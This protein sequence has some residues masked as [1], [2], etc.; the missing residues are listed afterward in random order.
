[1]L[2]S[3]LLLAAMTQSTQCVGGATACCST[4]C[5]AGAPKTAAAKA[6]YL[7]TVIDPKQMMAKA[8]EPCVSVDQISRVGGGRVAA[9]VIGVPYTIAL[10]FADAAVTAVSVQ[11]GAPLP[12]DTAPGAKPHSYLFTPAAE[13]ESLEAKV[14]AAKGHKLTCT[15]KPFSVPVIAAKCGGMTFTSVSGGSGAAS[16]TE[17]GDAPG[18]DAS[19]DDVSTIVGLLGSP[20]PLTLKGQGGKIYVYSSSSQ[21]TANSTVVRTLKKAILKLP[22]SEARAS[23]GGLAMD[24]TVPGVQATD[25][26]LTGG[27][28]KFKVTVVAAGGVE[29]AEAK[30]GASCKDWL[31]ELKAVELQA[32]P[33]V[34]ESRMSQLFYLASANDTA[35]VLT[36][37][38]GAS[39]G[40]SAAPVKPAATPVAKTPATKAAKTAAGAQGADDAGKTA[41]AALLGAP[42]S[43]ALLAGDGN[44]QTAADETP[45]AGSP[46]KTTTAAAKITDQKNTG[47]TD[48]AAAGQGFAVQGLQT[49]LLVFGG[50]DA[51]I[52]RAKQML[53]MLDLPRPEM[54]INT[55]ILQAST[56]NADEIG[57][58][59]ETARRLV[60]ENNEVLQ[61]GITQGWASLAQSARQPGFF[62][63]SFY[64]Y[65]VYRYIG[66]S[67]EGS[68]ADDAGREAMGVC[69]RGEYCLGYTTLFTPLRPR[70]T[71]VLLAMIASSKKKEDEVL[72][73]VNAAECPSL[74]YSALDCKAG[75][76]TLKAER[77]G[78][79]SG[80]RYHC[81]TAKCV[82]LRRR[83]GIDKQPCGSWSCTKIEQKVSA[84]SGSTVEDFSGCGLQDLQR[85]IDW[86]GS[87]AKQDGQAT[88]QLECFRGAIRDMFANGA[89]GQNLARGAIADFLYQYKVS[90]QYPQEFS[91]YNLTLS[92]DTL[93]TALAPFIDAFNRDVRAFQDYLNNVVRMKVD[94]QHCGKAVTFTDTGLVSVRTV[95]VNPAEV[96]ST[97]QSSLDAGEFPDAATLAANLLSG[98]NSSSKTSSTSLLPPNEATMILGALKSFQTTTAQIG[99]QIDV[100]VT[101]RSLPGA[102]AAEMDVT[103]KVDD[104]GTPSRYTGTT[105]EKLNLSR[106]ATHDTTTHVR[107]DSLKLFEVSSV[108]AQLTLSRPPIPLILPLVE[109]PYIGSL[110][111]IPRKPSEEYHSSVAIMSAI[112]VPTAADLAYG[113]TFVN[114]RIVVAPAGS[115][116][117]P[118]VAGPLDGLAPCVALTTA[119]QQEL[120]GPVHSFHRVKR[121][122]LSTG[123]QL[124]YSSLPP[125]TSDPP[126]TNPCTN[127]KFD[128]LIPET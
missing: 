75:A 34:K 74:S 51:S 58:F 121:Q 92:A 76:P 127:L 96:K 9:A 8:P 78:S 90:Q 1:M 120:G 35:S 27:S 128:T 18:D 61:R 52:R 54:I 69:R 110:V 32:L 114:D 101:P 13:G 38:I 79:G 66:D 47:S 49:D 109:M 5:E 30:S 37:T 94:C 2:A 105:S 89:A 100:K 81:E 43:D 3:F 118:W 16:K 55:W 62:D 98:G 26:A 45:A 73:G 46:Q 42:A 83:L 126:R 60:A 97:T 28:N 15:N 53:A 65:I 29:I 87:G 91:P 103:L 59:S 10:K 31:A 112:V 39:A 4:N 22:A 19:T 122:C 102:S 88:L 84:G 71:D 104:A 77:T 14:Q 85:L 12:L 67:G 119:S 23:S 123:D 33:P 11:G 82:E 21:T 95:S 6:S 7:V 99:R 116:R 70:L 68:P 64:R 113:I 57:M 125:D 36:K 20:A 93:N 48:G 115:C 117:M 111:G 50:D 124:G 72:N 80:E 17:T 107:V 108:G 56:T 86:T 106:V 40:G 25:K 24:L 44:A 41:D 63:D